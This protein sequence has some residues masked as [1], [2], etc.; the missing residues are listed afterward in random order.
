LGDEP[1]PAANDGFYR[2]VYTTTVSLR[3]PLNLNLLN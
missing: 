1:V 2:R 3:N